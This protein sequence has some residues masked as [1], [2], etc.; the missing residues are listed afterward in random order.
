MGIFRSAVS[1][2]GGHVLG[3]SQTLRAELHRVQGV[4]VILSLSNNVRSSLALQA[5]TTRVSLQMGSEGAS[6]LK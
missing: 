1:I 4:F 5:H 3:K 6:V 2:Y